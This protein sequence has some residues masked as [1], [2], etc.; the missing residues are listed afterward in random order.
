MERITVNEYISE[1]TR[2]VSERMMQMIG[3]GKLRN[4]KLSNTS[5]IHHGDLE[6]RELGNYIRFLSTRNF[7]DA[8]L[9]CGQV[10]YE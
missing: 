8:M 3:E 7:Y 4:H 6:E 9:L 5:A 10:D 2:Q 1:E